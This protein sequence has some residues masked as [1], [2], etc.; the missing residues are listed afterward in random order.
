MVSLK[1]KTGLL[2]IGDA[3]A[4][5]LVTAIGF[6]THGTLQTA[7]W[8]FLTTFLPMIIAWW[9]VTLPA[10]L[11]Q[12]AAIRKW[13]DLWKPVWAGLLAGPLAALLRSLWLGQAVVPVFALVLTAVASFGLLIWRAGFSLLIFH[14][15]DHG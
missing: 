11:M 9:L 6:A 1:Y 12:V 2:W 3:C 13:S 5:G 8:R 7:G 4:I 15:S 10:G 14:K